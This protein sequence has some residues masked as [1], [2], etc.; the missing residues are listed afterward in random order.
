[1]KI[2]VYTDGKS[3]AAAALR[4][5][6]VLCERLSAEMSVLTARSGT[7]AMESPPPLGVVLPR[8]HWSKLPAGIRTLA[9]AVEVLAEIGFLAPP[10]T[11]K[12]REVPSGYLFVA[13]AATG[14][15]VPFFEHYGDLI[16]VL[17][18]EVAEHRYDLVALA[19]PPRDRVGRLLRGDTARRLALNL[20]TSLLVVR[21][22]DLD[23]R[24]LVC[25]DGSP[26][27][28]R[29]FPLLKQLLPAL[30]GPVDVIF[31]QKPGTP[32]AEM[33]LGNQCVEKARAWLDS[34]GR[35]GEL[36][37]PE[38]RRPEKVIVE[39]AGDRSVVV[40]GATLRHDLHHRVKGS[41]P[42]QVLSESGSTMLLV[43]V[44]PEADLDFFGEPMTC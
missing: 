13:P 12:I 35:P 10:P 25:A 33:D 34:C 5:A 8:E 22:G 3:P 44:P 37:R 23:S 29:L 2:A 16:E 1:V 18:E 38:G 11:I 4:F 40:M 20:H 15:K 28:R 9:G 24:F 36:L 31:V 30:R 6:A 7:H 43:K 19:S 42:L 17:N 41:L 26:S 32:K 14:Q 39:R 21:E 27:A